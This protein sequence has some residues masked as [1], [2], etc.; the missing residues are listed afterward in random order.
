MKHLA[1]LLE[2]ESAKELL[3]N[4][5]PRV[6]PDIS[7]KCIP[8]EG[9]QD[10]QKNMHIKLRGYKVPNTHFVIL[11]DEDSG[12]CKKIKQNLKSICSNNGKPETLIRIACKELE[13][14]YFGDLKAVET[15]L[16]I[17]GL[18]NLSNQKKYR[19]PDNIVNPKE[20]LK[21]ITKNKYQQVSASREI[22][23][24]LD[25]K[26]NTSHSFNAFIDG[27]KRILS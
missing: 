18:E 24:V 26:N 12:N 25:Y 2:E 21:K 20:E 23:K 14:W 4:L 27:I 10:L 5:L 3:D 13:A 22:G 8:F 7:F 9:K 15:A 16:K 17:N 11:R 19:I 6:F 1:F